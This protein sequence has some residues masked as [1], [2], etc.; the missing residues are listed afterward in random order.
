MPLEVQALD[1][2]IE[3]LQA[4][5]PSSARGVDQLS[6]AVRLARQERQA[7][8]IDAY[9]ADCARVMREAMTER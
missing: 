5:I 2:K 3:A 8:V 7:A 1:R 9:E 6:A 4:I